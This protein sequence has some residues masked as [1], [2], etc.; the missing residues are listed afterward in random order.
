[1]SSTKIAALFS[2]A[3]KTLLSFLIIV[4]QTLILPTA[5]IADGG[6]SMQ[7]LRRTDPCPAGYVGAGI[8]RS[9]TQNSNGY[10]CQ[11]NP[12]AWKVEAN[13]CT[14]APPTFVETKTN[15]QQL[16]CPINTPSGST[17]QT[18]T[19]DVYSDG[20]T[21]N[22]SEWTIINQCYNKPPVTSNLSITMLEDSTA[23]LTL[24]VND[25]GPGPYTFKIVGGPV[26]GVASVTGNLL[27]YTPGADWNGSTSVTFVVIDGAGA[28]SEAA[29]VSITVT[30]VND[31]PVAMNLNI[32]TDEDT[33]GTVT[34]SATDIDSPLP[35][36]FQLVKTSPNGIAS[37]NGSLLTF[38]P[39]P[40]WNGITTVTYRAQ[41][42]AGAWSA[43]ATVSITVNP[44][45]DAPVAQ[46]KTL[47]IDED[48]TGN[49]TLSAT[50]VDSPTPTIFE[51]VDASPYGT[52]TISGAIMTFSPAPD[53]NGVTTITYRAQDTAGAWSAP[54]TVS[55]TVNP[56]NDAP[57]A[58]NKTLVIDEDTIGNVMLSATDIDSPPP[59]VFQLVSTSP[60]G[61]A[62]II[63][64]DLTFTPNP[65]WNGTTLVTYRA[66]DT[67]GAWSAPATV[68]ITVNPVN[69]VPTLT[70]ATLTIQTKESTSVT[71]RAAVSH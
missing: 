40:D 64:S 57:V 49:V 9:C 42:T 31:P 38:V 13:Y 1:M 62:N 16:S 45:N 58:Q 6:T 52:S 53:W 35:T 50:D 48:A 27:T 59:T 39:N 2:R 12:N 63:G 32:I 26:S 19:Y 44:V 55:I 10:Y 5:A 7:T 71:V 33:T 21:K 47:V 20:S 70:N 37:I 28:Q 60:Y 8:V 29:N 46:N 23:T 51:V 30:P 24:P 17:Y 65:N 11:R 56:V 18:Q 68:N 14:Y 36:V 67:A 4:T 22:Y 3:H 34:L 41:D 25:D 15:T 43:P 69:D 61:A 66:Q 54:A